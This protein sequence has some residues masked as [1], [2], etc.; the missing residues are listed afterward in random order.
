[1]SESSPQGNGSPSQNMS[2]HSSYGAPTVGGDGFNGS[3][4]S[5]GSPSFKQS[6]RNSHFKPSAFQSPNPVFNGIP[7]N[8]IETPVSQFHSGPQNSFGPQN[9]LGGQNAGSEHFAPPL[10]THNEDN[11]NFMGG[12]FGEDNSYKES[13]K[14]A[15]TN[16]LRIIL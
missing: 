3:L 12:G 9:S 10:P 11:R 14:S 4:M 6:N 7:T 16:Q 5:N 15:D 2:N 8:K 13:V 1:M